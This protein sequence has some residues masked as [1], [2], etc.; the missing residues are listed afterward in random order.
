[1]KRS[2]LKKIIKECVKETLFEEGVLSEIIAEVAFGITKAQ[3]VI[4]E[5]KQASTIPDSQ[6]PA[7]NLAAEQQ[8]NKR[9]QLLETKR[10]MLDA[11]GNDKMSKIFEGTEPLTS[12]GTPGKTTAHGPLAGKDPND[13]GVD[14]SGLLGLAGNKWNQL[15]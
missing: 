6:I 1:M 11:I 10:K 13:S 14:I 2:E 8:E 5:S 12:A 3:S 7:Q 9:K 15:K 4:A